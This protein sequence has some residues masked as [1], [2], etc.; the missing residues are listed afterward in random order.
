TTSFPTDDPWVT[1]TGGTTLDRTQN[2]FA[3][4]AWNNSLGASG[5]G[6]SAF[7][8]TPSYQQSLPGAVQQLLNKRRGVPDVAADAD[9][10]TGLA[11]YVN[12]WT[13]AGG[14]SASAPFWAAITAIANQVAGQPLGFLNVGLYKLG[15]S[16]TYARDFRDITSGNNTRV[17]NGIIVPGHNA[18]AGWD[19]VTGL[20]SP[21]AENLIP[22]LIAALQ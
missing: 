21:D 12:G 14:T 2:G 16:S 20:G 8:S 3:E 22:D 19:P 11:I 9:P 17:V 1:S 18:V 13:M 7:F 4:T 10:N 5:G 6:F 15:A